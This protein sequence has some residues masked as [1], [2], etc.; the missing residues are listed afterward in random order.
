MSSAGFVPLPTSVQHSTTRLTHRE[1]H[2]FLTT[3]LSRAEND[4]AYRPDSTLSERGPLALSS[5]STPNLTL[6]HLK[7]IV[8]GIEGR[9]V[10]GGVKNAGEE[11][12][13]V[14]VASGYETTTGE[15]VE[16]MDVDV[17]AELEVTEEFDAEATPQ[18][19]PQKKGTKRSLE[20]RGDEEPTPKPKKQKRKVIANSNVERTDDPTGGV[21][22]EALLPPSNQA[23]DQDDWQDAQT[24]ALEQ[25]VIDNN[26]T[27]PA[28]KNVN[29]AGQDN[30]NG[31]ADLAG[32]DLEAG[33]AVENDRH[34]GAIL[35]QP[36]SRRAEKAL[37]SVRVEETGEVVDPR[38]QDEDNEA[39]KPSGKSKKQKDK[40]K[41]KDATAE[42][43]EE[44]DAAVSL[45][46]PK[47]RKKQVGKEEAGPEDVVVDAP[48]SIQKPTKKK[49][50]R[51][52]ET[53]PV[54]EANTPI[55]DAKVLT[56]VEKPKKKK[57]SQ[58]RGPDEDGDIDMRSNG[59]DNSQPNGKEDE[60]AAAA[61]TTITSSSSKK[62]KKARLRDTPDDADTIQA[63]GQPSSE[64][65]ATN[66]VRK[67]RKNK[68]RLQ[69]QPLTPAPPRNQIN[70][71]SSSQ[72]T[73]NSTPQAASSPY[74]GL[75][76]EE[77]KALKKQRHQVEK[78]VREQERIEGK[79]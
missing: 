26:D 25:E 49:R 74:A 29:I 28:S 30:T 4:A 20:A 70:G 58:T 22:L 33:N 53:E 14:D 21:A 42:M 69:E 63:S 57:Q 7:R 56:S 52:V 31:D 38:E 66:E 44:V 24:F 41:S 62:Q 13:V 32:A 72:L 76:K 40:G 45:E 55:D 54:Q 46:K 23:Q 37:V 5:A 73:N 8:L 17:D 43:T 71:L 10:G 12:D 75:S 35:P 47:K 67:E 18:P 11:E 59:H 36:H 9:R 61:S 3:F 79:S 34:P 6:A 27:A 64:P 16:A 51:H 68:P 1:A 15:A 48:A 39:T 50:D 60:G 2:T 19:S 77:K 65:S 78:R